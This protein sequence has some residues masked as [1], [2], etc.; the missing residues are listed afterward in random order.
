VVAELKK[1]GKYPTLAQMEWLI[2]F[3]LAGADA[4]VWTPKDWGTIEIVLR[5]HPGSCHA[6][7]ADSS[8]YNYL[9]SEKH[10]WPLLDV[11]NVLL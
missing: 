8:L 4:Y 11:P 1:V 5:G 9:Q 6:Q 2:D 7:V 3:H 10:R